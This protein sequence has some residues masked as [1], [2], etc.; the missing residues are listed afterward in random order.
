MTESITQISTE[1]TTL[2]VE[3]NTLSDIPNRHVHTMLYTQ[4]QKRGVLQ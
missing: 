1:D 4:T 2:Y 3:H